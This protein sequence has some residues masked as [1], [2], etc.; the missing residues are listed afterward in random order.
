[1]GPKWRS[2]AINA[3]SSFFGEYQA[4]H[5]GFER[6]LLRHRATVRKTGAGGIG[7]WESGG[8]ASVLLTH[9]GSAVSRTRDSAVEDV[10]GG[11]A[12]AGCQ[13]QP[14]KG[15]Q[16]DQR[17]VRVYFPNS[18]ISSL[19]Q[20]CIRT[21]ILWLCKVDAC[22]I[23]GAYDKVWCWGERIQKTTRSS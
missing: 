2:V 16:E 8:L 21:T 9:G 11:R 14:A 22:K 20:S 3:G 19:P 7:Q 18:L 6:D 23:W 10:R 4:P 17:Y 15:V 1:M 13:N 12:P 5:H